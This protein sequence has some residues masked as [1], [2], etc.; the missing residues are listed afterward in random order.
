MCFTSDESN[1]V[2][3]LLLQIYSNATCRI[4]FIAGKN[5][6]LNGGDYVEKSWFIAENFS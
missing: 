1:D 3:P 6:Y 4:L 5:V 2:S